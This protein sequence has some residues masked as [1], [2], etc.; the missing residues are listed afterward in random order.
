[1]IAQTC[2]VDRQWQKEHNKQ[3]MDMGKQEK[4]A[5]NRGGGRKRSQ[6]KQ[7]KARLGAHTHPQR[8]PSPMT[9]LP[10]ESKH[11]ISYRAGHA[12]SEQQA[13]VLLINPNCSHTKGL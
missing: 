12:Q 9:F 10:L 8:S 2:S 13:I 3:K 5:R 7:P 11:A 6:E 1:M 4:D